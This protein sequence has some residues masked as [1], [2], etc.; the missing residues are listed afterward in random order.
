MTLL[1]VRSWNILTHGDS[2]EKNGKLFFGNILA[3]CKIGSSVHV[4]FGFPFEP[5]MRIFYA[6]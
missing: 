2:A 5:E 6:H 4:V 1:A 3:Q